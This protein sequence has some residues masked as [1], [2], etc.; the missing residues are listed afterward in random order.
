MSDSLYLQVAIGMLESDNQKL[1]SGTFP[2]HQLRN[3]AGLMIGQSDITKLPEQASMIG[4]VQRSEDNAIWFDKF[5]RLLNE[6]CELVIDVTGS[7]IGSKIASCWKGT[8]GLVANDM[9]EKK[10][11]N[12]VS[13]N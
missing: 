10:F 12:Q 8:H 5:E 13:I 3:F 11:Q 7:E 9:P 4:E 1:K 6:N 2:E